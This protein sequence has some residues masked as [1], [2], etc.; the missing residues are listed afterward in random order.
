MLDGDGPAVHEAG[1]P[2]M[3]VGWFRFFADEDRWDWSPESQPVDRERVTRLLDGNRTATEPF[4]TRDRIVDERGEVHDVAVVGHPLSDD[5]EV[6]GTQ[7]VYVHV[8][9]ADSDAIRQQSISAAVAEIA[10]NRS[11]IEQAKGMLMLIYRLDADR[12]FDLLKW[13]SQETNTRLRNLAAQ[14]TADFAAMEYDDTLP[15]RA[16]F[17]EILLTAHLRIPDTG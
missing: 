1:P 15:T 4:T 2:Q 5:G 13:R 7:G 10:E 14:L 16:Q 9:P 11:A 12:A 17:D 6:V 8:A 3:R